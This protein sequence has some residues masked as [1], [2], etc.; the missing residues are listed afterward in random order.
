[1]LE[2]KIE[3]AIVRYR[4]SYEFKPYKDKISLEDVKGA[5]EHTNL[6]PFATPDDIV[7]L[8]SEAKEYGLYG[9]CVNPCYVPLAERELEG[10]DVKVVTVVG[11]P[12]GAN[13]TRVKAQEAF[14]AFESGADEVDMVINIGM[15]KAKEWEYV[16]DDIRSVVEAA[17]G[18]TVKVIIETCYLDLEEKMAACVIS[19][20]AGAHYVKTSTGFGPKGATVE[21]VHL[22]KWIVGE[23]MKVKAAGG[24]RSYEDAVKML[25]Y[26]A[27]KIGTSSGHKIVLEGEEKY[28]D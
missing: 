24:I 11:F 2:Y 12:L 26:G 15:L 16:Y 21:D 6:K 3:E 8:C 27:E 5:I 18:K 7:K 17:R 14:F 23:D 22:M 9:V 10:T 25:M 1:M 28:G 13:E 4:E 19:K 20:I